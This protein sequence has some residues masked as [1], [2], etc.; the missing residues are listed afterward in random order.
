MNEISNRCIIL[1]EDEIF[2]GSGGSNTI[3]VVTKSKQVYK[4]F[5]FYYN[6]LSEHPDKA[7]LNQKKLTLC[8]INIGKNLSKNIMDKGISLH[9]VKF[10]GYNTCSN[11][12]KLFSKC[13]N[14]VDHLINGNKNKLCKEYYKKY[15][16]KTFDKEYIVVSLE[17]CDYSC[18]QFLKDLVGLRGI[19]I[20]YYLDI[21]FFQIIF[22]LLKTKETYPYFFHQDLFIRNI[23]GIRK[24]KNNN[25][26][27]YRYKTYIFDVPVESFFPKINDFGKSNL[28]EKYHNTKLIKDYRVD[29]FNLIWDV[30]DGGCL[31][32]TSLSKLFDNNPRKKAFLKLYFNTY[33]NIKRID[34]IKKN[35]PNFFNLNWYSTFDKNFSAF[36]NYKEPK[37]LLVKYFLKIFPYDPAHKIEQEFI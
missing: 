20:K 16:I 29:L 11:I 35:N 24:E 30:Y 1:P 26:Y 17:Y 36:I 28:N 31:G 4:F 22:T 25:Y 6:K 19:Q 14:F 3:I 2:F 37:Y 9:F 8:E 13:P 5:P 10:Y 23:L 21:F 18:E 7:I 32:S 34:N 15:P 12:Q 27:R 33:F